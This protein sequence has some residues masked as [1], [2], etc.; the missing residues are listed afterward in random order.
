MRRVSR[1]GGVRWHNAWANV[2]HVLAEEYV[3]LDEVDD[4]VWSVYFGPVPLGRFDER[5]LR[6]APVL[7]PATC[8]PG[9]PS[10]RAAPARVTGVAAGLVLTGAGC[11]ALLG[12]AVLWAVFTLGPHPAPDVDLPL[13]AVLGGSFGLLV[14]AV[15]TPLLGFGLLRAVPLWRAVL[16]PAVG[17]LV[18]AVLGGLGTGHPALGG[19]AGCA[20][21]ALRLRLAFPPARA[22]GTPSAPAA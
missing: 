19:L 20:A 1:N 22:R 8:A 3:G 15:A 4:G 10:R 14:G 9:A 12:T 16:E 13:A 11:G 6:P 21:A 2:S 17:T 7:A 5:D 18:G